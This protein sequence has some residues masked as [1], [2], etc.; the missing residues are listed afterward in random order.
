MRAE[1]RIP[2]K[3][4]AELEQRGHEVVVTDGWVNGKCMGIWY[5]KERGI[6]LGGVSPRGKIG[7]ALGW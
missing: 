7:Y 1:D 2:Q 5:D 3:V 4:I 6:I